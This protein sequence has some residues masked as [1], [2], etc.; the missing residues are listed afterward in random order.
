MQKQ[1]S[2]HREIDGITIAYTAL[3]CNVLHNKT[4]Q[5]GTAETTTVIV[6]CED[7][8]CHQSRPTA[9]VVQYQQCVPSGSD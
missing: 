3:I 4:Y 9:V 1:K 7:A 2:K 6:L 5:H 8:S